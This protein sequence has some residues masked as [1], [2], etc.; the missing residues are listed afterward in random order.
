MYNTII[1]ENGINVFVFKPEMSITYEI[2]VH[3]YVG[4]RA[5][6]VINIDD[7][8][9]LLKKTEID[10]EDRDFIDRKK[11]KP[12][13]RIPHWLYDEFIKAFVESMDMKGIKPKTQS[14]IEGE[15]N[16]T[17]DHLADL[18]QVAFKLLKI[19]KTD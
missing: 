14:L 18:K 2:W 4:G 15:L 9:G 11:F 16:A 3:D 5:I 8:S 1:N 19:E 6:T 13:M 7:E 12:F 17:K 10:D